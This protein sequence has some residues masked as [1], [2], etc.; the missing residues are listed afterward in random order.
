MTDVFVLENGKVKYNN[1]FHALRI[2]EAKA[3]EENRPILIFKEIRGHKE[4]VSRVYPN[5]K[6]DDIEKVI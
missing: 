2:A 1:F 3:Q 4:P 5:G 6:R